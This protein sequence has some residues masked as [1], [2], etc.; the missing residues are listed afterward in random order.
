[1]LCFPNAKI[2]I[3]L[4]II[5]KRPDNFH[6]IET[7]FYP[8]GLADALEII[9]DDAA[10]QKTSLHISGM[11]IPGDP[12]KN[13]ILKAYHLLEKI[14]HLPPVKIYLH[15]F[16]PMG[17]GLGGGSSDGAFMLKL[18]NQTFNLAISDDNL[19]EF[20]AQ[21]GSDCAFFIKNKPVF[22]TGKG[23]ILNEIELDLSTYQLVLV[24]PDVFVGTAEAYAGIKP[25]QPEQSLKDLL[26]LPVKDWKDTVKN[27]F[28]ASILKKYPA[29]AQVKE[30]MYK[31][32]ALYASM[33]GSGS[34]VYGIF[35]EEM[36]LA[37]KFKDC[38]YWEGKM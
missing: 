8:I 29:I 32:G 17:A 19:C 31:C 15:K 37:D 25:K 3:G 14:F 36:N 27:D 1:M 4:N 35:N 26:N 22:G 33:T 13:L 12:E 23:N 30:T 18:L 34:A 11:E 21:L 38:F 7:V 6:N 20:A 24:K 5:E 16:T 2:N 9:R 10:D 28:E